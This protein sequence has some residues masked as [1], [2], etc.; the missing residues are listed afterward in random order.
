MKQLPQRKKRR[1]GNPRFL[2]ESEGTL[3]PRPAPISPKRSSIHPNSLPTTRGMRSLTLPAADSITTWRMSAMAN[4][5]SG[6][7]GDT[8]SAMKVFK[9]FFVDIDLPIALI[10]DDEVTIPVAVL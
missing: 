2:T 1:A 5:L 4:T 7:I 8:T 3:R 6:A 10:Q 9:P